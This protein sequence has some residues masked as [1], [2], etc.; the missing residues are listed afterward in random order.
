MSTLTI[1]IAGAGIGGLTA[2]A[3]LAQRG[4]KVIVFEKSK[5]LGE[6][7]AGLQQGPNA[8]HVHE[9]LGI[10]EAIEAA[11]Y[12][13]KNAVMRDYHSGET[14]FKTPLNPSHQ[15][16]YGQKYITIHRADLHRIL[17]HAAKDAGAQIHLGEAIT[18]YSQS[19]DAVT[20]L[21]GGIPYSGD[22]LIGADGIHSKIRAHMLG[23]QTPHFTG[24]V[25]WRGTIPASKA[26]SGFM[27]S[28]V[29]AWLGPHK[30]F[31]SYAI[32]GGEL[33][34]FVAIEEREAWAQE[35]WSHK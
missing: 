21:A 11:G 22:A 33:I 5:T 12:A 9:A 4:A 15:E 16:R 2:A 20:I 30:H 25:A 8:M 27:D 31:I 26:P 14:L 13:P 23:E 32:R 35:G 3:A 10:R 28:D 6:V 7:G 19:R 17:L 29:T 34:N 18:D 1:L 24:Q